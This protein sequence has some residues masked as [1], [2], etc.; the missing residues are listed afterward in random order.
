MKVIKIKKGPLFISL[1]VTLLVFS[2]ISGCKEGTPNKIHA[3]SLNQP[4]EVQ[5][6]KEGEMAFI[7][8]DGKSIVT[9]DV[10]IPQTLKEIS[11]GLMFRHTL[12]EKQGMLF[13]H[14]KFKARFFWMKNTYIPL[15]MI[16]ADKTKNII[17]V[18]ENAA[19]LSKELIPI[20]EG[21]QY[22]IEVNSGFCHK[23]GIVAGDR[24]E[25]RSFY[26]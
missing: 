18:R 19:P 3:T 14:D 4:H 2:H 7:N 25:I 21:T 5:F 1:M 11:A 6:H 22:T 23:Y 16:F 12:A 8:K 9:I 17:R 10:E 24:V 13:E 15:D 20:P 26:L